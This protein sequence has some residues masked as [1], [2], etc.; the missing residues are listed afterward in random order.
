MVVVAFQ[1][2]LY[3]T[4]LTGSVIRC[5]SGCFPTVEPNLL[6]QLDRE[7]SMHEV[8]KALFDMA[9]LKAPG[10]DGLHAQFFQSQWNA[11][12]E[13]LVDMVK[14]GFGSGLVNEYLNKTLIVLIP[15]FQGP[16]VYPNF[17]LSVCVQSRI[18]C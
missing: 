6:G 15:K 14:K 11:V 9:P 17:A 16:E 18:S 8:R 5:P 2:N 4:E 12:V 13:S 3:I 7:V 1:K 10:I